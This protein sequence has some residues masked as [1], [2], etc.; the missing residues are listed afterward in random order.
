MKLN[1]IRLIN[2]IKKHAD[3]A[4]SKIFKQLDRYRDNYHTRKLDLFDD[5]LTRD[6]VICSSVEID[7]KYYYPVHLLIDSTSNYGADKTSEKIRK[8]MMSRIASKSIEIGAH[9]L[10]PEACDWGIANALGINY[11]YMIPAELIHNNYGDS[12]KCLIH[13]LTVLPDQK[14][15]SEY[16]AWVMR[17]SNYRKTTYSRPDSD[18]NIYRS[19]MDIVHKSCDEALEDIHTLLEDIAK[20]RK[21]STGKVYQLLNKNNRMVDLP[22]RNV[23]RENLSIELGETFDSL[24]DSTPKSIAENYHFDSADLRAIDKYLRTLGY[25]IT[26]VGPRA[27]VPIRY[28]HPS[29]NLIS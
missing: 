19:F 4:Y 11:R 26:W 23:L 5:G 8:L 9:K 16:V 10:I 1:E 6:I 13:I 28:H 12:A 29:F 14:S 27:G 22:L 2:R 7:G 25:I 15:N 3:P 21:I 17:N 24:L 20:R 18:H